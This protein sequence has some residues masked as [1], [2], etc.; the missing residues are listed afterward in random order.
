[1]DSLLPFSLVDET[2]HFYDLL[3]IIHGWMS[4]F[5]YTYIHACLNDARKEL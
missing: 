1:M 3:R 4:H 2:R 5:V